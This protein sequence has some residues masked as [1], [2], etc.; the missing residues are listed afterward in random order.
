M[1][2][3]N[4]P[5]HGVSRPYHTRGLGWIRNLSPW[6][7]LALG[8]EARHR[9][10]QVLVR[11][12]ALRTHRRRGWTHTLSGV[13]WITNLFPWA[14]RASTVFKQDLVGQA[15][16][17]SLGDRTHFRGR[18]PCPQVKDEPPSHPHVGIG[19]Q[20]QLLLLGSGKG[21]R[22]VWP[23]DKI[24]EPTLWCGSPCPAHLAVVEGCKAGASPDVARYDSLVRI[25]A[26][27]GSLV[28]EPA[29]TIPRRHKGVGRFE[30]PRPKSSGADRLQLLGIQVCL[31]P[32]FVGTVRRLQDLTVS[33]SPTKATRVDS[34][35][36]PRSGNDWCL[37]VGEVLCS[38]RRRK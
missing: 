9:Q 4:Q 21:D 16:L 32:N 37:V 1:L 2:A 38:G 26:I 23:V 33:E 3:R 35:V 27:S 14:R 19:R 6:A 28:S 29:H 17:H 10:A 22:G 12:A 30:R 7:R 31:G 25:G 18:D 13:G 24:V 36:V 34:V 15:V 11:L 5:G 8:T 20:G